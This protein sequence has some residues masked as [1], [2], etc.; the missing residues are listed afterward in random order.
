MRY[1]RHV[2]QRFKSNFREGTGLAISIVNFYLEFAAI[3]I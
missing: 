1:L 3:L 2:P